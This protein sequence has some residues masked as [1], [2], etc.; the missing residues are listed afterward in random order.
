MLDRIYIDHVDCISVTVSLLNMRFF[1]RHAL[2]ISRNKELMENDI[3]CL[4]ES[5]IPNGTDEAEMFQQLI[6]F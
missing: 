3:M 4:T 6:Y 5:Q 1:V 2:D